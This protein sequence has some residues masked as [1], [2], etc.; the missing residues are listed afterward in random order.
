MVFL[1]NKGVLKDFR[2]FTRKHISLA[3]CFN[4]P[5]IYEK[6]DI[7]TSVSLLILPSFYEHLYSRTCVIVCLWFGNGCAA[8]ST[9]KIFKR[10]VGIDMFSF[11]SC[12]SFDG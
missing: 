12:P 6:R 3:L 8:A 9:I 5:A 2:T 1:C 4:K 10:F 7:S 11:M